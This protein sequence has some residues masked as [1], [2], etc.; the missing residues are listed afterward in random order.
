MTSAP[1][2]AMN[3]GTPSWSMRVEL[4]DLLAQQRFGA[5]PKGRFDRGD[6]TENAID[7]LAG[8]DQNSTN[9]KLAW[10]GVRIGL[11]AAISDGRIGEHGAEQGG[12]GVAVGVFPQA[13]QV[14]AS[15]LG[16]KLLA[17]PRA[18]EPEA[19]AEQAHAFGNEGLGQ[20]GG[21]LGRLD[22]EAAR[23]N[24]AIAYAIPIR[25]KLPARWLLHYPTRR[26]TLHRTQTH[27][28]PSAKPR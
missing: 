1:H 10:I 22:L 6:G 5:E 7:R 8:M 9:S 2:S 20:E 28:Q 13:Q 18:C 14:R 21:D 26:Q 15:E 27:A 25:V 17:N 3:T 24:A 11:E 12:D 19:V 16:P 23:R 4:D